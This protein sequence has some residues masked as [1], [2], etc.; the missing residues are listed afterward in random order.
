[1][2]T[3]KLLGWHLKIL[4]NHK[5][6]IRT[7]IYKIIINHNMKKKQSGMIDTRI[8]EHYSIFLIVPEIKEI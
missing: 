1:M 6:I 3:I 5:F 8:S 7:L 4:V 2:L